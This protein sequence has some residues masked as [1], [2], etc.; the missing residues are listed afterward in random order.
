MN[1]RILLPVAAL[2]VCAVGGVASAQTFRAQPGTQEVSQVNTTHGSYI[3]VVTPSSQPAVQDGTEYR[4]TT[5]VPVQPPQPAGRPAYRNVQR[6]PVQ[7]GGQTSMQYVPAAGSAQ[8]RIQQTGPAPMQYGPQAHTGHIAA[9]PQYPRPR[10]PPPV[11]QAP[12][13]PQMYDNAYYGPMSA[14]GY[15]TFERIPTQRKESGWSE[16]GIPPGG[17]LGSVNYLKSVGGLFKGFLPAPL[18]GDQA[19][20][21]GAPE[22]SP[23]PSVIFVPGG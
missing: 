10:Q 3:Q 7:P 16:S 6:A 17:V 21:F 20:A 9:P 23:Q 22:G 2:I 1:A 11:Q 8:P 15:P 18:R 13:V 5:E 14:R 19:P 12:S 4:F